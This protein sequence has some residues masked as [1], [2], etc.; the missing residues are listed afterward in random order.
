MALLGNIRKKE[1]ERMSDVNIS[2]NIEVIPSNFCGMD[3]AEGNMA[4]DL[5]YLVS[6]AI[7]VWAKKH[8]LENIPRD[9][10]L[11]QAISILLTM[12]DFMK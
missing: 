4:S 2:S 11:D 6:N 8:Q 10:I 1:Q 9:I 3:V 7:T 5:A 12:R